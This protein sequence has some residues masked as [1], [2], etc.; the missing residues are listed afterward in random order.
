MNIFGE[1]IIQ[2]S[3]I[4]PLAPKDSYKPHI[5]T[6]HPH[7]KIPNSLNPLQLAVQNLIQVS[8]SLEVPNLILN[9]PNQ[10]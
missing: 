1:V 3:T 2:P 5:Q 9:H 10:V 7:P 6:I 8:I 4:H